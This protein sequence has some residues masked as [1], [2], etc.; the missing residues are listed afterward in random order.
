MAK[1]LMAAL[2]ALTVKGVH[3]TNP[4]AERMEQSAERKQKKK[5]FPLRVVCV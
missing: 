2:K 5:V 4:Q 1:L 3:E